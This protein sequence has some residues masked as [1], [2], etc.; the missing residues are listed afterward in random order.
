MYINTGT[1]I[2]ITPS[3]FQAGYNTW[4]WSIYPNKIGNPE[5][6]QS[7]PYYYTDFSRQSPYLANN[8]IYTNKY[9]LNVRYS[10]LL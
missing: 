9:E 4:P 3:K 2:T 1:Q 10:L 6:Y 5:W 8:L 7:T